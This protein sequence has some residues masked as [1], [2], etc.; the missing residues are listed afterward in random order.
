[1]GKTIPFYLFVRNSFI[2]TLAS[3]VGGVLS[4]SLVAY[5]FSHFRFRG[6]DPLFLLVLSTMMLPQ[7]VTLIPTYLLYQKLGWL[8]TYLPLVVP[9][10][11]G[12]GAF[13]IF[14]LRQFFLGIPRD[15]NDAAKIDGCDHFRYYW[16]IL[17]PLSVPSLITVAI[18]LFQGTWDE[19]LQPLIYLSTTEKFT[20]P[21]GL[22]ALSSALQPEARVGQP[23]EQLLMAGS[24]LSMVPTFIV[25]FA[26]QRYFIRG[27]MLSGIKG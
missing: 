4:A 27:V 2:V 3:T 6:R 12:G 20:V 22:Q 14:L 17:L 13:S 9:F 21:I 1:V 11:F 18:L 24:F 7:E 26:L 15:F 8:D 16:Q 5:G 10:Y 23:T 19:F 25:F